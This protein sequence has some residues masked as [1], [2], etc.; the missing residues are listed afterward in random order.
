MQWDKCYFYPK[1]NT[2]KM[3]NIGKNGEFYLDWCVATLSDVYMH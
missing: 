1:K 2:G 3:L